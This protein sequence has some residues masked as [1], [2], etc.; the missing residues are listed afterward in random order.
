MH[1]PKTGG[2]TIA[3]SLPKSWRD[4]FA[5]G[6]RQ[7]A[8][9]RLKC[10]RILGWND[11]R[12]AHLTPAELIK[13]GHVSE[14]FFRNRTVICTVRSPLARLASAAAYRNMSI[15]RFLTACE[16]ADP[17]RKHGFWSHCRA[18]S[19]YLQFCD[20]LVETPL[21]DDELGP[22]LKSAG[23]SLHPR[24]RNVASEAGSSRAAAGMTRS[25]FFRAASRYACD[26]KLAASGWQAWWRWSQ[27]ERE[28]CVRG[29]VRGGLV[30]SEEI[31]SRVAEEGGIPLAL[32]R[33]RSQ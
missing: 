13:C 33:A 3:V 4:V 1:I 32:L 9:A 26:F 17:I 19:D 28:E 14:T 29:D 16:T 30:N 25:D 31:W 12:I 18:Q 22:L 8:E 24:H 11:V 2:T 15:P 10:S 6:E 7:S 23:I 27:E 20:R 5:P 21:I